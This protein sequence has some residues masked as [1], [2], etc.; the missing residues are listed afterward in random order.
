MCV[1]VCM[2]VCVCVVYCVCCV[3]VNML[4]NRKSLAPMSA[5]PGRTRTSNFYILNRESEH[6]PSFYIGTYHTS[7]N[8]SRHVRNNTCLKITNRCKQTFFMVALKMW[9]DRLNDDEWIVFLMLSGLFEWWWT[10]M[11]LFSGCAWVRICRS[12]RRAEAQ[13]EDVPHQ[14]H[15]KKGYS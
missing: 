5:M 14:I 9:V 1:H 4:V 13:V 11:M 6:L 15:P 8:K 7:E 2:C 3:Q 12:N 10:M